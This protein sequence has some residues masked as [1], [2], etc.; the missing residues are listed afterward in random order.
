MLGWTQKMT[1]TEAPLGRPGHRVRR[2]DP[3]IDSYEAAGLIR[4]LR[5]QSGCSSYEALAG[6]IA[7]CAATLFYLKNGSHQPTRRIYQ[8]LKCFAAIL[9]H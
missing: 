5:D 7:I 6:R 3:E 9:N 4:E 2:P 8:L 1:A